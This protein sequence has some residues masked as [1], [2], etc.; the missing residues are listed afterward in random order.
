[1]K[2]ISIFLL[3]VCLLP[4]VCMGQTSLCFGVKPGLDMNS[5]YIGIN[6]GDFIAYLG[7][8]LLWI[9]AS[10]GYEATKENYQTVNSIPTRSL[11]VKT[12]NYEGNAFI[13]VPH[14]GAKVFLGSKLARPYV[15]GDVFISLPIVD[16]E[17]DGSIEH[18]QYQDDALVEHTEEN[19]SEYTSEVRKT[20][21]EV[22]SFWGFTVGAGAEYFF[23]PHFSVGGEYGL[24]VLFDSAEYNQR[25][26]GFLDNSYPSDKF[27]NKWRTEVSASLK[28]S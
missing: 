4:N 16:L 17:A 14:L 13:L 25:N 24:R 2:Y 7:T 19:Y 18:W 1:M 26:S 20:V 27:Q 22:V 11:E 8:D 10:A 21:K 15:F 9:S 5:A 28:V 23:N 3:F 12:I 6:Q